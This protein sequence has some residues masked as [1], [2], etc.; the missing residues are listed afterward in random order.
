MSRFV[1]LAIRIAS[2]KVKTGAGESGC[3]RLSPSNRNEGD[4]EAQDQ[5]RRGIE[6]LLGPNVLLRPC[7]VLFLE[8]M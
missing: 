2:S 3:R 1:P 4:L 7:V 8:F 5:K 6:M